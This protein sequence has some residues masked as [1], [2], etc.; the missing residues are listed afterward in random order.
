MG[1]LVYCA[2]GMC[3]P[4]QVSFS[5]LSSNARYQKKSFVLL[6]PHEIFAL[7]LEFLSR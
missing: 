3:T 5:P 7:V 6:L 4:S 2:D 1:Y